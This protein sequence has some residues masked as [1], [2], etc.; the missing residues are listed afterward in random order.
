MRNYCLIILSYQRNFMDIDINSLAPG[1]FKWKF[2]ISNFQVSF[3]DWWQRCLLWKCPQMN[4]T[5]NWGWVMHIYAS[6]NQHWFRQWLVTWQAPSHCLNQCWN[7]VRWTLGTHSGDILIKIDIFSFTK[8][9]LKNVVRK[10]ATIL[11]WPQH[12]IR[13]Q[14]L[15]N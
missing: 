11:S 10:M 14:H 7:I 9:H 5:G 15:K 6:V 4:V 2:Y 1:R 3:R 12:F 13:N 8:M